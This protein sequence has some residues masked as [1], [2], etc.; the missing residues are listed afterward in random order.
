VL[1]GRTSLDDALQPWGDGTLQVLASGPLP[2]NP[3]ELL[4]SA[5][6]TQLMRELEGRVDLV[7]ID[8]PPLLPV[9]DAAVLGAICSGVLMVVHSNDT[10]REQ[11]ARAV[12]TVNAVGATVLGTI[13]NMVPTKGPDAYAYGYGYGYG[14]KY[15]SRTHT[16]RFS[17]DEAQLAVQSGGFVGRAAQ[18]PESA[19]V[20]SLAPEPVPVPTYSP[21]SEAP[22]GRPAGETAP[23]S[24][25][26]STPGEPEPERPTMWRRL[27]D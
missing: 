7:L 9:T 23:E 16:G 4:G 26:P 2:P 27:G 24:A 8:A 25:Y 1:L 12:A 10:R 17:S 13:L 3:S 21:V 15:D 6:M 5:G 19:P 14:G 22:A 20:P 11:L 18:R